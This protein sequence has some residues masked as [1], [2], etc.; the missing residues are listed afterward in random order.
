MDK[1]MLVESLGYNCR[2]SG[3]GGP[4]TCLPAAH[5]VAKQQ[6]V[7]PIFINKA[8]KTLARV[9]ASRGGRRETSSGVA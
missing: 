4:Q 2:R 3:N 1:V 7:W 5:S 6:A 8:P 9:Q